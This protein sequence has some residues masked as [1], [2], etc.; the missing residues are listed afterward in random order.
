MA[1]YAGPCI[2]GFYTLFIFIFIV[3]NG[4]VLYV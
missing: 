3:M 2:W 4:D 1:R